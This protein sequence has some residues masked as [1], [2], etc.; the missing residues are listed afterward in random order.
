MKTRERLS[1]EPTNLDLEVRLLHGH[2]DTTLNVFDSAVLI[3]HPRSAGIDAELLTTDTDHATP[4]DIDG[5]VGQFTADRIS[6][7]V[8][9]VSET[10]W[11]PD[12]PPEAT[13]SAPIAL[14]HG[15]ASA[16][17]NSTWNSTWPSTST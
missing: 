3:D 8:H 9:G 2:D 14:D 12:G 4:L 15:L 17:W 16:R 7:I 5:V 1:L 11:W 6:A 10:E 13:M